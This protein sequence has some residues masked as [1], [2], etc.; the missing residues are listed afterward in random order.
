MPPSDEPGRPDPADARRREAERLASKRAGGTSE[1]GPARPPAVPRRPPRQP[2]D[3]RIRGHLLTTAFIALGLLA[4]TLLLTRPI[5]LLYVLGA[6]AAV[7][8]YAALHLVVT[9]R[10][11]EDDAH[12]PQDSR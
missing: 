11:V 3:P 1:S 5:I 10:L 8:L 6:A 4:I 12:E 7:M 2:L 9:R